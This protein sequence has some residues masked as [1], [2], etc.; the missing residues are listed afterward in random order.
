[1]FDDNPYAAPQTIGS[2]ADTL[3]LAQ[4]HGRQR[5]PDW[6]TARVTRL[7]DYSHSIQQLTNLSLGFL[8]LSALGLG[9]SFSHAN[10]LEDRQQILLIMVLI[11]GPLALRV[12]GAIIARVGCGTAAC[13]SIVSQGS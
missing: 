13:F 9:A 2:K 11:L 10:R 6:D 3:S 7:A 1:M 8:F 5:F 4:D 12:W